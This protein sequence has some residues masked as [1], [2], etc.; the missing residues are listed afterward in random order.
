[1]LADRIALV[2]HLLGV[3]LWVGSFSTVGALGRQALGDPE[4]AARKALYRA[5]RRTNGY[6]LAGFALALGGGL[7]TFIKF[8]NVAMYLKQPWMHAKLTGIVVFL[9]LHVLVTLRLRKDAAADAGSG[10]P[11]LYILANALGGPIA[12][13]IIFFVLVKPWERLF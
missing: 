10:S 8:L 5:A 9:A 7:Y 1:M 13:A 6:A 3:M 11:A 12:F 2:V 4:L